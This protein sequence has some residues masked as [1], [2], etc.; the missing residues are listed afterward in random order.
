MKKTINIIL[1]LLLIFVMFITGCDNSGDVI[2]GDVTS[3]SSGESSSDDSQASSSYTESS[4]ED[5]DESFAEMTHIN[6]EANTIT[7]ITEEYLEKYWESNYDGEVIH[8]LS[9]E[10]VMQIIDDSVDLFYNG[11][12]N[13]IILSG[14]NPNQTDA[15]IA[16][17]F[18]AVAAKEYLGPTRNQE[19]N[20]KQVHEIIV[21]RLT[22]LSSPCAFIT[23]DEILDFLGTKNETDIAF[24]S[25]QRFYI[26]DYSAATDREYL[27]FALSGTMDSIPNPEL[28]SEYFIISFG[29]SGIAF[30]NKD[31]YTRVYP[32]NSQNKEYAVL[33]TEKGCE[34]CYIA[35]DLK[36]GQFSMG[37]SM[38][39]SIAIVGSYEIRGFDIV[40]TYRD[41]DHEKEL[42]L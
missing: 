24:H 13:K 7:L 19:E 38:Y 11:G 30:Y 34:G 22:L 29:D 15:E 4:D 42:V 2:I 36:N 3:P 17:R 10:E 16:K 35:L 28:L 25:R 37:A 23:G 6:K 18:P 21:H 1:S 41:A 8:A 20:I 5:S 31:G 12:Y 14:Y 39:M 9:T 40:L 32:K 27:V 33:L 26:P